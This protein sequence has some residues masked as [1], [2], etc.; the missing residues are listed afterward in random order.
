[1]K[2]LVTGA[3]GAQGGAV[4]RMLL[5]HSHQVLAMTRNLKSE[6]A[7]ELTL[8]DA[9][10]VQGDMGDVESIETALQGVDGVFSMQAASAQDPTMERAH[11]FNLIQAAKKLNIKHFVHTSVSGTG[12]HK[13]MLGWEEGRW[14]KD[15]WDNKW[16]IEEAVRAANFPVYTILKPAF[17]MENFILPKVQY[18]FPDLLEGKLITAILPTTKLAVVA[19]EDI[20][21]FAV[22][23]FENPN[24]F[25]GENIELAGDSLTLP[26]I[27]NHMT[28]VTGNK[29]KTYTVSPQQAIER[30]QFPGWVKSQEW[31]NEVGY[32]ALVE[33]LQKYG[34]SLT[35]FKEWAIENKD[36]LKQLIPKVSVSREQVGFFEKPV[37]TKETEKEV[38]SANLN[39]GIAHRF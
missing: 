33:Q 6:Q 2:I 19:T 7:K 29:V 35:S 9:T 27:A 5:K 16:D 12:A 32:P 3:T 30:G 11:G 8:L 26:E 37:Q 34:F 25:N 24:L 20:A 39:T 22:A 38:E 36:S 28:E 14:D 1:M 31:T 13:T 21:K 23:A 18:M 4:L 15:Y 10:V 17:F